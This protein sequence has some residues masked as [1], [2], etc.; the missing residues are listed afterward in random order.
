MHMDT[1]VAIIIALNSFFGA[2]YANSSDN[3]LSRKAP[4]VA[5]D[6]RLPHA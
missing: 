1:D 4:G 2:A 3:G 6:G 5:Q